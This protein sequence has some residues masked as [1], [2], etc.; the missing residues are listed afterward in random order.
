MGNTSPFVDSGTMPVRRK[1]FEEREDPKRPSLAEQLRKQRLRGGRRGRG[2]LSSPAG[3]L[4]RRKE[5]DT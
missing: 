2:A 4:V 1:W 3:R 5:R